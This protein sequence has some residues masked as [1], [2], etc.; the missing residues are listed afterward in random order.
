MVR[1]YDY[2]GATFGRTLDTYDHVDCYNFMDVHDHIKYLK[3]GYAKVTD[4][5]CREIRHGRLTRE[6]ALA[7]VRHHEA[8]P[9]SHLNKFCD[10]LGVDARALAFIFNQHRNPKVWQETAPGDWR[11]QSCIDVTQSIEPSANIGGFI[12]FQSQTRLQMDKQDAYI[13]IGKGYP[14]V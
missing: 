12:K 6:Q 8:Q 14:L 10:W 3:H 2:Q 1:Q 4:H 5:A 9:M 13:T 7:L 11:K